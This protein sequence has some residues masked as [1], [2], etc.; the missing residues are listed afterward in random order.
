MLTVKMQH[1]AQWEKHLKTVEKRKL[2]QASWNT[3]EENQQAVFSNY[4]VVGWSDV[5][6]QEIP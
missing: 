3:W 6:G 1:S 2:S 5:A 4:K